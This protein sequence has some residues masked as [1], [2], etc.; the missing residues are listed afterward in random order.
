MIST[1]DA[2]HNVIN[3]IHTA[4]LNIKVPQR[5]NP[6]SSHHKESIFFLFNFVSI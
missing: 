6:K 2:M 3:I 5:V 1:R 4:V